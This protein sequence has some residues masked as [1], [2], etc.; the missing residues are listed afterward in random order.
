MMLTS[1]FFSKG[2][3]FQS[4]EVH[5]ESCSAGGTKRIHGNQ[6]CQSTG[7][8]GTAT[9]YPLAWSLN[10]SRGILIIFLMFPLQPSFQSAF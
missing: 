8:R 7:N 1:S 4:F 5:L 10:F 2:H 6:Y 3:Q 9:L